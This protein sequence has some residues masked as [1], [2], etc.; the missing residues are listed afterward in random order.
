VP[1]KQL[2]QYA[3]AA[4]LLAP[5]SAQAQVVCALGPRASSYRAAA[6]QR[7]T[8][9]AMQLAKRVNAAAKTICTEHCPTMALYRNSTAP[10]LM[11]IA[12][13]GQAKLV[14][15]PQ[16]FEAA[17]SSF[18]D[19]GIMA[20]MAHEIGHALD[21]TLGAAWVKSTWPPELRADAW[22]GCVL[23]RLAVAPSTL[24]PALAALSKYPSP[25]HPSW[26]ARLPVLRTGYTHCGGDGSQFGRPK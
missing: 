14:Y 11:L 3:M 24:Q 25:S 23:A 19:G 7:P 22:A 15:S 4:I 12:D 18:G 26:S 10:N 16:F 9:D 1:Q 13:S 20:V 6:D 8:P 21:A 5:L 17:Y 2:R